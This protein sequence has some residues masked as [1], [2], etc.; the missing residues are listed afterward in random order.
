MGLS[1]AFL[2][3]YCITT[4]LQ[5]ILEKNRPLQKIQNYILTTDIQKPESP[6]GLQSLGLNSILSKYRCR[7]KS[8]SPTQINTS[9]KS[10]NTVSITTHRYVHSLSIKFSNSNIPATA[11]RQASQQT[12]SRL[13][14]PGDSAAA[15]LSKLHT[16]S[17]Q[18]PLSR[19][20]PALLLPNPAPT[21]L[22]GAI[23]TR[24]D[25][26]RSEEPRRYRNAEAGRG[27]RGASRLLCWG[28]FSPNDFFYMVVLYIGL[29]RRWKSR[30][31]LIQQRSTTENKAQFRSSKICKKT[32]DSPSN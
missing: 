1:A 26:G 29:V 24:G 10:P 20:T 28:R 19:P 12:P 15:K 27:R 18:P 7:S 31:R 22:E 13:R 9:W 14:V 32:V 23:N 21:E 30:F 3:G 16:W 11:N 17:H 2:Y 5:Q 8:L 4:R 6:N 25:G